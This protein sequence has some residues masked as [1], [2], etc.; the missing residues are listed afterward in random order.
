[1]FSYTTFE[2]MT[3]N[4]YPEAVLV[5]FTLQNGNPIAINA[6][7]IDTII[8]YQDIHH[9]AIST[10]GSQSMEGKYYVV[11]GSVEALKSRVNQAIEES[12][13]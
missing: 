12:K 7:A 13:G 2:F 11:R 10:Y 3:T 1:M 9:S 5:S 4:K 8:M 6:H